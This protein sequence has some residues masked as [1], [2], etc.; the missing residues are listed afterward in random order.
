M[1]LPSKNITGPKLSRRN[2][3]ALNPPRLDARK[4]LP[5]HPIKELSSVSV[6]VPVLDE[7]DNLLELARQISDALEP[8]GRFFELILVDDGSTD[9]SHQVLQD[10]IESSGHAEP[11]QAIFLAGN[12]GQ[13][14][15]LKAGIDAA[16]G[17]YI[18]TLDGD[19][20]NDPADIPSLLE[21][22]DAG[23]EIVLGWRKQRQDHLWS[24]KIP[25]QVA[26]L[27]IRQVTQTQVRDLGCGLKAMTRGLALRLDLVGDMHRFI[28]VLAN[29]LKAK[30]CE[31]P[32][33]HR[34][35]VRGKTK[36]GL[37]RIKRVILDLLV[38]KTLEH[39]NHP[40]RF[41]GGWALKLTGCTALS[42]SAVAVAA[43]FHGPQLFFGLAAGVGLLA[44]LAAIQLAGIG[45]LA[46]LLVRRQITHSAA[47]N[48]HSS[49]RI[50]EV[51]GD[52]LS[53]PVKLIE[54]K[55]A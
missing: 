22:L 16:V 13:T 25:S 45:L 14:A 11:I 39:R 38:L 21:Q 36:Y 17:D 4:F 34:A 51:L 8:T 29:Q 27:L 7:A 40:M 6:V 5:F 12:F 42:L 15:A 32:T 3:L 50:Q 54:R 37:S 24:R 2:E 20:Q 26:N 30:S 18:V 10:L 44:G 41:F 53:G 23:F 46:E 33:N 9:H 19:L 31:V 28:A 35:R 43:F 49:Y 1:G 55:A 52:G 48:V 47:T